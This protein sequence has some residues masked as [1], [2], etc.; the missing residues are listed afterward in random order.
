MW[1]IIQ[2]KIRVKF[3]CKSTVEG[4][5]SITANSSGMVYPNKKVVLRPRPP[6]TQ[7]RLKS[8]VH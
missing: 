2:R 3:Q 7:W 5:H 8:Y 6:I 4:V 1:Y